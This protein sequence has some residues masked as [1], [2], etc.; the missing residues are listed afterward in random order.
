MKRRPRTP[1]QLR[2]AKRRVRSCLVLSLLVF[3]PSLSW[4]GPPGEQEGPTLEAVDARVKFAVQA[5]RDDLEIARIVGIPK[6]IARS[7][8]VLAD[9]LAGLGSFDEAL[10]NYD[11]ALVNAER[12]ADR[13]LRVR[14]LIGSG[15]ANQR[16]RDPPDLDAAVVSFARAALLLDSLRESAGSDR[17]QV[18][19]GEIL[20]DLFSYWTLAML[21]R[22]REGDR[23]GAVMAALAVADLGRAQ[24]LRDL[25]GNQD[26]QVIRAPPLGPYDEP[27][28]SY[29]LVSSAESMA[30]ALAEKGRSLVDGAETNFLYYQL[31]AD[32]LLIWQYSSAEGLV[33]HRHSLTRRLTLDWAAANDPPPYYLMTLLPSAARDSLARL[34]TTFR[35]ALGT[36]GARERTGDNLERSDPIP[37]MR[38]GDPHLAARALSDLLLPIE[39][40]EASGM[41]ELVVVPAAFIALAPF[42][43]LPLRA[44]EANENDEALLGERVNLRYA[45][46]LGLATKRGSRSSDTNERLQLAEAWMDWEHPLPGSVVVGD[47]L[48]PAISQNSEERLTRLPGAEEEAR[49]IAARLGVEVLTG[50]IASE[51]R[52]RGLM[53]GA[54]IIHL[55]T[56]GLAY[57]SEA[58]A[59][60]SF[61]ALGP[62]PDDMGAGMDGRLT[63]AEI[64]DEL[65]DL[66]ADLVVLSACQTGLGNVTE[67]EGTI[68]LQRAFLARGA[69]NVLVSLWN[70]SDEAT[71]YL[72]QRFYSYWLGLGL[73][74]AESL[75]RA[76]QDVRDEDDWE[77]PRFWA[78]FQLVGEG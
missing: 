72:M 77:H 12:A 70:V 56:H 51:R 47:P 3:S 5:S 78:A 48:M 34:V 42:S 62:D 41:G 75:R 39:D 73:S 6:E 25:L 58:F 61:L 59:R 74:K 13:S 30:T 29:G 10:A 54:P 55:A 16:I 50:A 14:A 27:F 36:G 2:A 65:P 44:D 22:A 26:E 60:S 31:A 53:E 76:Q 32:T 35:L 67:S 66:S 57:S 46:S 52:V 64:V 23:D 49:W 21:G 1:V 45:P 7:H 9:D 69:R 37:L 19:T 43:A 38:A 71:A 15:I 33:L 68:G 28:E 17:F 40:D 8:L 4:S 63:V 11:S 18:R 20:S 24:A